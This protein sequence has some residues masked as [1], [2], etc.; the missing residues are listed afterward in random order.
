MRPPELA[1]LLAIARG[2]QRVVEL[3]TAMG[4]TAIALALDDPVRQVT[5][6]DPVAL[7]GERRLYLDLVPG[8]VRAR[9]SFVRGEGGAE[10][11]ARGHDAVDLLF[12]D[13]SHDRAATVAEFSAWRPRL[14]PGGIVAFHDFAH[15]EYPGV[16][17]AVGEL[18]LA[19]EVRGGMF[20]WRAPD[21][22]ARDSSRKPPTSG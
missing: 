2:R 8:T 7:A 14:A 12:I 21:R 13:S 22:E 10:A 1:A 6:I 5:T 16:A 11:G 9:I 19:G 3:G 17:E 20:V 4:W 18:E 15:P